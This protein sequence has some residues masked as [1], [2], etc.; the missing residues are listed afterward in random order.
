[1]SLLQRKLQRI[2]REE[3]DPLPEKNMF[4]TEVDTANNRLVHSVVGF[5]DEAD[6]EAMVNG[7]S[8]AMADI[9]D[10]CPWFDVLVDL[11][12]AAPAQRDAHSSVEQM[13]R[14]FENAPVRK[15]AVLTGGTL[16][17]LQAKRL[18][19]TSYQPAM[20]ETREEAI[21][22]LDE[23]VAPTSSAIRKVAG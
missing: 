9:G 2:D 22:W 3:R 19:G 4:K 14:S 15:V 13:N 18:M 23:P 21:A 1:M 12:E 11:S 8:A 5:L 6:A 7:F 16:V 17:L 10:H 20:F